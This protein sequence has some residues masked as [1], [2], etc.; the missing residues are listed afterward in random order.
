M[1]GPLRDQEGRLWR[2]N[3]SHEAVSRV[4]SSSV[5]RYREFLPD[6]TR[7]F[8]EACCYPEL[9]LL[10]YEV[11]VE[12]QEVPS[13]VSGYREAGA[14]PERPELASYAFAGARR[15]EELERWHL[16]QGEA[17]DERYFPLAGAFFRLRDALIA[18]NR[19]AS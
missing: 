7:R 15:S 16:L 6:E 18:G 13:V 9:S 11:E 1:H 12:K 10:S 8:V 14:A 19:R 5:G 4:E 2:S 3:S 17:C